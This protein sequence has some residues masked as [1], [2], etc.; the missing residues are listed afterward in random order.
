MYPPTVQAAASRGALAFFFYSGMFESKARASPLRAS[1]K[2][3]LLPQY[4]ESGH[5]LWVTV[6][7]NA[8][9]KGVL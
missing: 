4:Y 8:V 1:I 5:C 9:T 6:L 7:P 2:S 3:I